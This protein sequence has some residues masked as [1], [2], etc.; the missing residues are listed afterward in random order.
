M[1][2]TREQQQIVEHKQGHARVSAV[3]GSGKT[4]AMVARVCHLL[5]QGVASGLIRVLMFNRSASDAFAAQLREALADTGMTV[6]TVHTFHALGLRLVESFTRRGAL[7]AY[8]LLTNAY[9][10]EKFAREAMKSYGDAHGGDASW[11]TRESMENFSTFIDLVKS[12]IRSAD[13][14][15]DGYA[16]DQKQHYFVGAYEVFERL[17]TAAGV[18]FFND[19]IHEP[20]M[21][22]QKDS[23]LAAWVGN[24]IE[25]II[26]DEYQD[27]NEVQQQLLCCIAGSRAQVMVV[28]DVDQCIYEW[29]GARPEYIV[30]RFMQDFPGVVSYTLSYTFRY[31]HRLSL[32][33]N[34]LIGNNRMRDRKLCLSHATTPDTRLEWHRETEP[35]PLPAILADW[36]EQGR[37]L[38][39]AVVLVRLFA[40]AVPVELT[41]LQE[42]IPYRLVG[43]ESVFFCREIQ[44]LLGYLYLCQG[45]L[46]KMT[47]RDEAH[48]LVMAMLTNPQLW[49][50]EEKN[51][52]LAAA[53]V[54]DPHQAPMLIRDLGRQAKSPFLAGRLQDLAI[55]WQ[56]LLHR[57]LTDSA[58]S[59]LEKVIDDTGL[60]AFFTR[61]SS[62]GD[63]AN[64]IRTCRAFVRFARRRNQNVED[65][66]AFIEQLRRVDSADQD[67]FL[68]ITSMHRAKGLEWP[69]VILPGLED[70]IVPYRREDDKEKEDT[71]NIE[72]ERRLMYVGM[73][74]AIERLCLLYPPDLRF[75]RNNRAGK[76]H[77]PV[78]TRDGDCP[79]ACFLYESNLWLSDRVGGRI[80]HPEPDAKPLRGHN[81][82]VV[83]RYLAAL[84]AE[85]AVE[86]SGDRRT[87]KRKKSWKKIRKKRDWLV[88]RELR[89]GMKVEHKTLGIG[90]IKSLS[91]AQGVVTVEFADHNL[92]NLVINLAKLRP[93]AQEKLK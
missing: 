48:I 16:L 39:E 24:H 36:L 8:T 42:N 71:E 86:E 41:L 9:E 15:F 50:G 64:K 90:R 2:L 18:R 89:N 11:L 27:I 85:V 52:K 54:S 6:P 66:L 92:Q 93:V 73:T 12:D 23:Q 75:E 74:R 61:F 30:S 3:A 53:I 62:P 43:H 55:T 45:G 31:G 28:G 14:V 47:D 4:T 80:V 40:A 22:I 83:R 77:S 51:R 59:C 26:V 67:D 38:R 87:K 5:K 60:F 17:R 32:A 13:S 84:Q 68:L 56:G 29:R 37:T 58:V 91:H 49:Q 88:I 1:Q 10:Q 78:S 76:G 72:D 21:A 34:H 82:E 33:A 7:P 57:P 79:A 65:F 44:A 63:A 81:I 35:S 20:V 19:L 69:L 25:H 70:G 46:E